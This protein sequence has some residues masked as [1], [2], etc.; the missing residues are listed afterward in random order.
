VRFGAGAPKVLHMLGGEPLVTYALRAAIASGTS[1]IVLVVSDERVAAVA[2]ANNTV[3]RNDDTARGIASSLQCALRALASQPGVRAVVVGL[4][5]QPLVGADA[6]RRLAAAFDD[7][8][9]LAYATY[10]GQRGNPVLIAREH[11]N[12]ALELH[13]DEGARALFRRHGAVAVPCDGTGAP[14][15]VDTPEDFAA[16]ESRWR[17]QT[18]S[19]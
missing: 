12:E 10:A 6:Y 1:P 13:G 9:R 4:A 19:E 11:W 5:D 16:L 17:S 14:D 8:A 18:A 7:G 2:T 15:D 3:V